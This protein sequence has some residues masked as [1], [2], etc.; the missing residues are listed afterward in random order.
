MQALSL[1]KTAMPAGK[2]T[3]EDKL[4]SYNFHKEVT[5][6]AS[7]LFAL[8]LRHLRADFS[9]N[10]IVEHDISMNAPILGAEQSSS[11]LL[12]IQTFFFQLLPIE[13]YLGIELNHLDSHMHIIGGL[14]EKERQILEQ[15]VQTPGLTCE[16]PL[17]ADARVLTVYTNFY[18]LMV[19]HFNHPSFESKVVAS[20]FPFT[21]QS[22]DEVMGNFGQALKLAT[23]PFPFPWAQVVMSFLVMMTITLPF[24]TVTFLEQSWIGIMMSFMTVMTYW[25]LNEVATEMEDPFGYDPNDLPLSCFQYDLNQGLVAGAWKTRPQYF[26]DIE[27]DLGASNYNAK[28]PNTSEMVSITMSEGG[29]K[30]NK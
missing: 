21:L 20:M 18:T 8:M 13:D 6:H 28:V 10:H 23:T 9:L 25:S 22:L 4:R 24:V 3:Q 5:H 15:P 14:T 26:E 7:L 1:D 17:L 27:R 12:K 19:S 30:A 2:M 11:T 29:V 16:G